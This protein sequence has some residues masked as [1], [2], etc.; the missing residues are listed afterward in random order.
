MTTQLSTLYMEM[1]N[2][3]KDRTGKFIMYA[4]ANNVDNIIATI[5]Y[6]KKQIDGPLDDVLDIGNLK[7]KF[8]SFGW[9]VFEEERGNDMESIINVLKAAKSETKKGKP[10]V[11]LLYTE[12][13]NGVDLYDG[14]TQMAW[15]CTK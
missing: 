8:E 14:N 1:E 2:Y 13:G 12:M 3:K 9:M 5:D 7:S 10:I 6:N 11:I 15:F 4:S